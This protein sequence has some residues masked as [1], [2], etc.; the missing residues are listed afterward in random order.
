MNVKNDDAIPI[1]YTAEREHL[2]LDRRMFLLELTFSHST[3]LENAI[4][5][6]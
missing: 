4:L 5:V 1:F 3:F 6:L 2:Q